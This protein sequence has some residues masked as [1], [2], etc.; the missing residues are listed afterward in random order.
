[1]V[2][3]S[4]SF[5]DL[6]KNQVKDWDNKIII[7]TKNNLNFEEKKIICMDTINNQNTN[8]HNT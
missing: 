5:W 1:M 2:L 8:I 4:I 6:K 3:T 7:S